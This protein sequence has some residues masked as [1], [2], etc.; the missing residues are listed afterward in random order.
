MKKIT[1]L[2]SL[3]LATTFGFSQDLVITGVL[4]GPLGGGTPKAIELYVINDIA[5][6]SQYG[7]GSANNGGGTDGEEFTFPADSYTAGDFI[8]IENG[9]NNTTTGNNGFLDFFGFN[10]TYNAGS[11]ASIN[12]DDAIELFFMGGVIDV[13]G[14]INVDGNGE[15]WEYLDGWAYR[16]DGTGPDGT[17]FVPGN[18]TYSG[19]NALD[20]ETSN[21]T[22]A[23]PFPIGTYS[24]MA[25]VDP[26][27]AVG[28]P[29]ADLE[30]FAN[31]Y[32]P[33]TA[34]G[35][36]SVSGSNLTSDITLTAPMG[37]QISLTSGAGFADSLLLTQMGGDVPNTT[38]YVRLN[39]MLAVGMYSGNIDAVS[40]GAPTEMIAVSGEV[41]SDDPAIV[42]FAT[43]V[44]GMTYPEGGTSTEDQFTVNARFLTED[45][46][47]TASSNFE[48]SLST[49]TG[50]GPSV[51]VPA[52]MSGMVEDVEVYSR[53]AS[54]LTQGHYTG[55][56]TLTSS[57]ETETLPASGTVFAANPT[58]SLVL[59]GIYDGTLSGGTPK[60]VEVY[61][62]NDIAD[63]SFYGLSRASNGGGSSAGDIGYT[64]PADA[65]PAGTYI[66][67]TNAATE[68]NSYFGYDAT[69]E[70][71]LV[72]GNGD[73]AYELYDNGVI[74]DVFGDV[75]T[76]GSGEPWEYTDGWAYRNDDTGPDGNNFVIGNWSFSGID[77]NDG[78]T[79]DAGAPTPFPDGTYSNV[80]D[81]TEVNGSKFVIF[82]NP[83]NGNVT[84]SLANNE[85]ASVAVYSILGKQVLAQDLSNNSLNITSLQSGIY[86]IKVT[87]GGTTSTQKLVVK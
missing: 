43:D 11:T 82:P 57:G 75:D 23:T 39:D 62:L 86:L 72:T 48:V 63:L 70:S 26:S 4:D 5:D 28:G 25:S 46:T 16:V 73:D 12:G 17:T 58:G 40:T 68:F 54:G 50:F 20:G 49:G 29:V 42:L 84:V 38:I 37:F 47:V 83:S 45:I 85:A 51:T 80:L 3:L 61:T 55:T 18:F 6:L 9:G 53:L 14:D 15:V 32:D 44:S 87:Q 71:G 69:Y 24:Q 74:N 19:A 2:F 56:V 64:F 60:V 8:Y 36:T 7:I 78:Q 76:D 77:A 79:T 65:V 41:R 35:Q 67:V 10:A 81:V 1:L 22:A 27:I 31:N 13:F 59:T 34:E 21:S 52:D 66:T 30:Y 33:V